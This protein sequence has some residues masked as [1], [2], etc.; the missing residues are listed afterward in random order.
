MSQP[1]LQYIFPVKMLVPAYCTYIIKLF[2][3]ITVLRKEIFS[4]RILSRV[5][6]YSDDCWWLWYFHS[7]RVVFF[8]LRPLLMQIFVPGQIF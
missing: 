8:L 1:L 4:C 7:P 2:W 5:A 6:N 3:V